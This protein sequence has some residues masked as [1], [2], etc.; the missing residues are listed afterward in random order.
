MPE[1]AQKYLWKKDKWATE[2]DIPGK[3]KVRVN[4]TTIGWIGQEELI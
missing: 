4:L 2:T 1:K 3:M